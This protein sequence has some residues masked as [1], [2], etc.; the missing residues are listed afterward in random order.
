M[1]MHACVYIYPFIQEI[2]IVSHLLSRPHTFI[3]YPHVHKQYRVA[4]LY[5]VCG[6]LV[7]PD[8]PL[9]MYKGIFGYIGIYLV[10]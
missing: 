4:D 10:E 3:T 8:M 2:Y 9:D 1:L 6:P 5:L 7:W